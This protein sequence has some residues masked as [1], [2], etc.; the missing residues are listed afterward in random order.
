MMRHA[1]NCHFIKGEILLLSDEQQ[2]FKVVILET[3]FTLND[4]SFSMKHGL[5]ALDYKG[6]GHATGK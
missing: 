4:W 6:G 3:C 2:A 5:I 1:Y